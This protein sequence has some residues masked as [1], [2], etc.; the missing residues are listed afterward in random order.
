MTVNV[1]PDGG[2][3][4]TTRNGLVKRQ[5]REKTRARPAG[6]TVPPP[7]PPAAEGERTPS[8]VRS[9]LNAFR[10]GVHRGEQIRTDE[11]Q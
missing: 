1:T 9:M 10:S 8:E 7:A 11:P 6:P 4:A 3:M 5:P 2:G